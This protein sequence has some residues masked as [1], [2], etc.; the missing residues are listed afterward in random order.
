MIYGLTTKHKTDDVVMVMNNLVEYIKSN[1]IN[2]SEFDRAISQLNYYYQD[3][4]SSLEG[5]QLINS[6]DTIYGLDYMRYLTIHDEIKSLK[7]EDIREV[8]NK[9]LI[10]PQILIFK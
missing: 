1:D 6:T 7:K 2:D 10:N 3:R 8:A 4:Q 9:F 5:L